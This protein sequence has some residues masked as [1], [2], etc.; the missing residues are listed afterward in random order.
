MRTLS[1]LYT[2]ESFDQLLCEASRYSEEMDIELSNPL[3]RVR[4]PPRRQEATDNTTPPVQL[5]LDQKLQQGIY[6]G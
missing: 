4:K 6:A 1:D 3:Q 5:H 2:Q